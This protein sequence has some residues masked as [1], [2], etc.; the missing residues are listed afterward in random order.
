MRDEAEDMGMRG[1]I[2]DGKGMGMMCLPQMR[3]RKAYPNG[4]AHLY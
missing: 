1:D 4:C 3:G 2:V